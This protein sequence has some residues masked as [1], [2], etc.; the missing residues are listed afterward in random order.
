MT[1]KRK[2]REKTFNNNLNYLNNLYL[3]LKDGEWHVEKDVLKCKVP[4]EGI[5]TE[6]SLK[7]AL[8]IPSCA[9]SYTLLARTTAWVERRDGKKFKEVR[10]VGPV[11]TEEMMNTLTLILDEQKNG[12]RNKAVKEAKLQKQEEAI[13]AAPETVAEEKS[14]ANLTTVR[15][16]INNHL[17]NQ[18]PTNEEIGELFV[19]GLKG[20]YGDKFNN[21]FIQVQDMRKENKEI[22]E[23]LDTMYTVFCEI[24]G[25]EKEARWVGRD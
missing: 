16:V 6:V 4:V 12:K 8:G 10:W 1:A 22:R 18:F 5:F 21:L 20:T 7:E 25:I 9:I 15:E 2:F 11:P 17:E 23:L 19:E 24:A 13:N 14:E 3:V